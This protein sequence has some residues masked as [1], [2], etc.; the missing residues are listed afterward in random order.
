MIKKTLFVTFGWT[1]APVISSILHYGL[2]EGDKIV[3]I[4]PEQRDERSQVALHDLKSF[5]LGYAK[6]IEINEMYISLED[7]IDSITKLK[8]AI[9]S[10]RG[11]KCIVNLS[12]GMRAIVILAYLATLFAEHP[13]ITIELE[14]E[15]RKR[16][17]EL[18]E[19]RPED[20]RE[21]RELPSLAKEIIKHL[22]SGPVEASILR[23][24]FNLPPS[25]FHNIQMKL[26][27]MGYI[28]R[29][30]VNK[31]IVLKLTSRGKLLAKLAGG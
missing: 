12:G 8:N 27:Q 14:T 3:V 29:E 22:L 21:F 23:K 4:L 31:F 26:V 17:I 20:L 2:S 24:K 19:I 25:S 28:K 18:P 1:E 13:E 7:P 5:I 15:D 9:E 6:D 16:V 30:R 11:R 10:E